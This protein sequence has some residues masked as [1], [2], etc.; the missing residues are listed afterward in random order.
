MSSDE[1]FA[2]PVLNSIRIRLSADVGLPLADER[3]EMALSALAAALMA[4]N[5]GVSL[6]WTVQ[7][8]PGADQLLYDLT[9]LPDH[10]VSVEEAWA[11]SYA[12]RGQPQIA[13]AEPRFGAANEELST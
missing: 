5:H 8:M 12:L 7:A 11:M 2:S 3:Q 10:P 4:V 6:A 9:P 1:A 13:S